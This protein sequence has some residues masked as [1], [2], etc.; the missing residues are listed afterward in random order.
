MCAVF[1]RDAGPRADR[2]Q[3][4]HLLVGITITTIS[5]I[6]ISIITISTTC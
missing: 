5:V 1:L 6:T 4:H 2:G 3:R